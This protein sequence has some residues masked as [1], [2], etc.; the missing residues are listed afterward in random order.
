[1]C[2]LPRVQLS[3]EQTQTIIMGLP[4]G[5]GFLVNYDCILIV[6]R[7]GYVLSRSEANT[8]NDV[9]FGHCQMRPP[10]TTRSFGHVP[11]FSGEKQAIRLLA[12]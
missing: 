5:I 12:S 11:F 10:F 7:G 1:M 8:I 2:C 3:F 4:T 9:T 6:K